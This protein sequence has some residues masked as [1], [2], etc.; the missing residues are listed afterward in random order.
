MLRRR[1]R[2]GGSVDAADG[3]SPLAPA[4]RMPA[5]EPELRRMIGERCRV[6]GGQLVRRTWMS[7][8]PIM[9]MS[10]ADKR[11]RHDRLG[12]EAEEEDCPPK[13]ALRPMQV[14]FAQRGFAFSP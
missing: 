8:K 7:I 2:V 1:N 4:N 9:L 6:S 10:A 14:C 13:T 11:A 5:T 3:F 12:S